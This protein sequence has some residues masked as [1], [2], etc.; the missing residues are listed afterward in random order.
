[1]IKKLKDFRSKSLYS[2]NSNLFSFLFL[3]TIDLIHFINISIKTLFI[4]KHFKKTKFLKNKFKNHNAFVLAN[5]PSLKKIDLS[6]IKKRQE[7]FGDKVLCLNSFLGKL[8]SKLIPDFYVLSDP[9]YFGLDIELHGEITLKEIKKDLE[10]I[11]K[12]KIPLF[13][14]F[15]FKD[16]LNI[17]TDVYYFNDVELRRFN[18]NVTDLTKPRCYKSMTSFKSLAIACYLGFKKIYISGFDNNYFKSVEVDEKNELSYLENHAFKQGDS[19]KFTFNKINLGIFLLSQ[20]YT[21][22]DFY[23]FPKN[24]INLD[25]DSLTDALKKKSFHETFK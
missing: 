13:I 12:H 10:L 2:H 8:S 4:S 9:V 7:D 5:G 23:K 11:E 24:I 18:K 17:N 3:F 1:M 6:K 15:K 22:S 16:N 19:D 25:K 14:P 20:S 21:F